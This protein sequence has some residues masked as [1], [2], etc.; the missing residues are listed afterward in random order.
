MATNYQLP[1]TYHPLPTYLPAT[2]QVINSLRPTTYHPLTITYLLS[3][4][5]HQ[6]INSLALWGS[7]IEIV[8]KQ[9]PRVESRNLMYHIV[10]CIVHDIVL[11]TNCR[12]LRAVTS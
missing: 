8:G 5:T 6:V 3:F 12:V 10:H 1:V 7:V 4:T 2:R 9:L 11:A